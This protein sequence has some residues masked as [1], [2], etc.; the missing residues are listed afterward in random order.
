MVIPKMAIYL[1]N[2]FKK[3]IRKNPGIHPTDNFLIFFLKNGKIESSGISRNSAL[4][5]V[6]PPLVTPGPC[7]TSSASYN[8]HK[9]SFLEYY[10]SCWR[11]DSWYSWHCQ[12]FRKIYR[13]CLL[14][15]Y[16][17]TKIHWNRNSSKDMWINF[18]DILWFWWPL[19]DFW[20]LFE[21]L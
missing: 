18:Y 21:L 20:N 6:T 7:E 2:S 9:I 8:Q 16:F 5:V 14:W 15:K 17:A 1:K 19:F 12:H 4:L 10:W 11:I 3:W 13:S